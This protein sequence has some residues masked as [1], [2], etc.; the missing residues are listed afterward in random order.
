LVFL[1]ASMGE[2]TV[3]D[4]RTVHDGE[5]RVERTRRFLF[6]DDDPVRMNEVL[7]RTEG[8]SRQYVWA[9]D[10]ATAIRILTDDD[11]FDGIMLDHDLCEEHYRAFAEDRAPAPDSPPT[12]M[13]VAHWLVANIQRFE[14]IP[15][16][17]HT[18]NE[19][20]GKAMVR[21]MRQAG[22]A[23]YYAPWAWLKV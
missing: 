17:V 1:E 22:L 3:V 4:R 10:A 16:A 20:A 18:L 6:M 7:A 21:L 11:A 15:I 12:G 2:L 9:Q 23:A 14:R 8:K 19:L 5:P 13:A